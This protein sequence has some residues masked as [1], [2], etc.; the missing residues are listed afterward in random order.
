[1]TDYLRKETLRRGLDQGIHQGRLYRIGH[2]SEGRRTP[3]QL[4]KRPPTEWI[5]LLDHDYGWLRQT[6]QRL[7][8]QQGDLKMLDALL[9]FMERATTSV[10]LEHALWTIEGLS[11]A[12]D[13]A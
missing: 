4:S 13:P 10:G 7:L 2:E 8:I 9:R 5:Q 6:A 12:V 11:M 3:T 1:M